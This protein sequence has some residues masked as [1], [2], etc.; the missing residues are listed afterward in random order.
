[1]TYTEKESKMK[2]CPF[3]GDCKGSLCMMWRWDNDETGCCRQNGE[4]LENY[5]GFCGLAGRLT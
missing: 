5:K 4:G 3:G 1:M 2:S